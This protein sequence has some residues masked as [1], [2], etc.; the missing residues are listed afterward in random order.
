[1]GRGGE[2]RSPPQR[3]SAIAVNLSGDVLDSN[4]HLQEIILALYPELRHQPS[5]ASIDKIDTGSRRRVLPRRSE[6]R[7]PSRV[8]Q[9]RRAGDAPVPDRGR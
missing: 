4:H 5:R 7:T 1:M 2:L 9:V 3:L 6:L 8:G